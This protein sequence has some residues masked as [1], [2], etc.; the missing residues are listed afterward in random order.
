MGEEFVDRAYLG[1]LIEG[2]WRT[3]VRTQGWKVQHLLPC[4]T[5]W[6]GKVQ[7][8]VVHNTHEE[9]YFLKAILAHFES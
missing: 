7:I 1:F 5:R 3:Q 9:D 8:L 4:F 2:V 6:L